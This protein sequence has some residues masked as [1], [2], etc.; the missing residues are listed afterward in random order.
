VRK[1]ELSWILEDNRPVRD[2]IELVGG[3]PYKRYRIYE[4]ALG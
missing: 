2:I 4:K 1:A 3:R